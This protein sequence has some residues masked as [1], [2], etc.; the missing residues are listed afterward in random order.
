[1]QRTANINKVSLDLIQR[2]LWL[3]PQGVRV[4]IC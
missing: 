4:K 3:G 1:M 2:D